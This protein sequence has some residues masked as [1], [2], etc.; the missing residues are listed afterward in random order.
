MGVFSFEISLRLLNMSNSTDK[1][2]SNVGGIKQD[3]NMTVQWLQLH[4][5]AVSNDVITVSLMHHLPTVSNDNK[6]VRRE[7]A[8][9]LLHKCM[10]QHIPFRSSGIRRKNELQNKPF[11]T[12]LQLSH[13]H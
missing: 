9:L 13:T 11:S 1:G 8:A 5:E 12:L 2:S 3:K 6:Y 7:G 4:N 10:V